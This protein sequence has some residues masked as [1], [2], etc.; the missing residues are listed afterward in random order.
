[1]SFPRIDRR[2]LRVHLLSRL[3]VVALVVMGVAWLLHDLLL[4]NL[5]RDF[6]GER[7]HKEAGYTI[8][9]LRHDQPLASSW[10]PPGSTAS[11][12]LHHLY[13]LRLVD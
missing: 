6:V 9:R 12:A 7:L 2:I 1:M 11:Q 13:L 4:G 3:G 8:Q 5:A 10:L